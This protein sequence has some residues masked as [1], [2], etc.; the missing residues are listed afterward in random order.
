MTLSPNPLALVDYH[1]HSNLSVDA[2]DPAEALA[3]AAVRIGLKEI[4]ISEHL[5]TDPQDV[6]YGHYNE[7]EASQALARAAK[8]ANG[9][10][11]LRKGVEVCYQPVLHQA[12]G[13]LVARCRQVD[14]VIGSVHFLNR[15][16]PPPAAFEGES[17]HET[18]RRYIGDCLRA[19]ESGFF[20][21]LGHFEY[22][23][24]HDGQDGFSY[25]PECYADEVE[26]L[27]RALIAQEMVLELNTGGL[28]R[29]GNHTYPC[30]WTLTRYRELGGEAVSV[31]SDAHRAAEV[32]AGIGCAFALLQEVGF[33]YVVTFKNRRR[34]W[35]NL[36]R[37][38][39]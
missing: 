27:L 35:V 16:Y 12:A 37:F 9:Q 26:T 23:R 36:D 1:I 25:N 5:D 3:R 10:L 34:R 15:Q 14:Y 24:R 11:T 8:A 22:L 28:R 21:I 7:E 32:G 29:P 30:R 13:D 18:Y 2:D 31:G 33:R 19:V 38:M 6:G 17:R 39:R 20:D 4:G